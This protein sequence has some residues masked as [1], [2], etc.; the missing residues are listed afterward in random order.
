MTLETAVLLIFLRHS[1]GFE[2][3]PASEGAD[4]SFSSSGGSDTD[5][6]DLA[7]AG[8]TATSA[9]GRGA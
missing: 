3:D 6:S 9:A 5:P 4:P 8:D 7:V 1:F 2:A